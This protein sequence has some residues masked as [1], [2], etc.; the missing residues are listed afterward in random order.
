MSLNGETLSIIN[1]GWFEQG[2]YVSPMRTHD[3]FK[4]FTIKDI[5]LD[6]DQFIKKQK[7]RYDYLGGLYQKERNQTKNAKEE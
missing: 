2:Y 4:K 6:A 5:F 3:K 7:Q 1:S